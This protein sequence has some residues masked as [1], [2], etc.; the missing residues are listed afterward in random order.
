MNRLWARLRSAVRSAGPL[1]STRSTLVAPPAAAATEKPPVLA[2]TSST[3]APLAID[4]TSARL[5]RWSRKCPVLLPRTTSA[6]KVR[7]RSRNRT[8]PSGGGPTIVVAVGEPERLAL[9]DAAGEAQDDPLRVERLAQRRDH[10]GE[11]GE[12]DRG[13]QLDDQR[14]VVAVDDQRWQPVVLAVH[15]AVG[16][17]VGIGGERR[18]ALEGGRDPLPPERV[19]DRARLAVVQDLDADRRR[20][21]PQPDRHE[22]PVG[23]EHDGE[24]AGAPPPSPVDVPVEVLTM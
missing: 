11:V 16:V 4:R 12:P 13:V 2:N 19:V 23:I 20:R 24:I 10:R 9:G 3:R 22:A 14:A 1:T 6:S 18:A 15:A 21:I 8:G 7:P 5:S 17:G